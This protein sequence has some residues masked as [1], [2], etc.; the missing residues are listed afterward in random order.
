MTT[1]DLNANE[2]AV[3]NAVYQTIKD[4]NGEFGFAD[5]INSVGEITKA[6]VKG[7][8]SQLVQKDYI[9]IDSKDSCV[10]LTDKGQA[11]FA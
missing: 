7:Y 10:I 4:E 3:L 2:T 1:N 5:E 8:L 9:Q 6:Q 11:I